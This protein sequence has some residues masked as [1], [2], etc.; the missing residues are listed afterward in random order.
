MFVMSDQSSFTNIITELVVGEWL[1][2]ENET[3]NPVVKR[4]FFNTYYLNC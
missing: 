2:K 1:I 4:D 3:K